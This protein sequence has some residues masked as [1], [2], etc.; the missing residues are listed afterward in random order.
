MQNYYFLRKNDYLCQINLAKV[1]CLGKKRNEFLCFALD[2]SYLCRE[3]KEKRYE[4]L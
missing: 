3:I 4:K 1:L 2:F